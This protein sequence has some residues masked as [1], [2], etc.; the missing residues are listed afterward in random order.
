MQGM[1]GNS[2]D[3]YDELASL[4]GQRADRI[5]VMP[6]V[7]ES[8]DN[9]RNRSECLMPFIHATRSSQHERWANIVM[10]R[11]TPNAQELFLYK[12]FWVD[13]NSA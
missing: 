12:A 13:E 2:R 10:S 8:T 7:Q 3:F 9:R 1:F 11:S 6:Q 5:A 4:Q